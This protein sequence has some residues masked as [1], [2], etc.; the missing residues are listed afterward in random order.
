M[1]LD[2]KLGH[3]FTYV[4]TRKTDIREAEENEIF[5]KVVKERIVNICMK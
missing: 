1:R 3:I 4:R 5:L 2:L